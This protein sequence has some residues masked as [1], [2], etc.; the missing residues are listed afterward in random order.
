MHLLVTSY[1][2]ES[3]IIYMPESAFL[4]SATSATEIDFDMMSKTRDPS[5]EKR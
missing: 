3:I 2:F 4:C 5:D 1:T